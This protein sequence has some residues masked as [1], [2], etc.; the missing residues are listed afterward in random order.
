MILISIRNSSVKRISDKSRMCILGF[1]SGASGK[2]PTCQFRRHKRHGFS[3]WVGKI[4]EGGHGNSL[5]YSCL[6][7]PHG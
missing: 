7:D 1:S 2:E 6:E 3:P 4:T 5:Q